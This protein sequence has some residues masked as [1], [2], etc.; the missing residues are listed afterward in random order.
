MAQITTVIPT[1]RRPRLL[2]RAIRSV[3]AQ[4]YPDFEIH[5]WDNASG[6]ETADVVAE[7]A[8]R[9]PRA[10]YHCHPENIGPVRNF[11]YGA[12]QVATPFFNFLSDDDIL[13]PNFFA[14]GMRLLGESPDAGAFAG[15][16]IRSDPAGRT[17]RSPSLAWKPGVYAPPRG[18]FGILGH[19]NF[20]W[21]SMLFRRAAFDAIGGLDEAVGEPS[22]LDLQLRMAARFPLVVSTDPCA[23]FVI[24][25]QNASQRVSPVR[26][27][28]A[29]ERIVG[30]FE[31]DAALAA[32]DREQIVRLMKRRLRAEII[33]KSFRAAARGEA[34]ASSIF[35]PLGDDGGFFGRR[36]NGTIGL[37]NRRDAIGAAARWAFRAADGARFAVKHGAARIRLRRIAAR[38]R[39]GLHPASPA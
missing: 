29:F 33:A 7:I 25:T 26:L 2:S 1:Y 14:L 19:G 39:S 30:K 9:D 36:F 16:S 23:V 13:L 28:R 17:Y 11:A 6:D 12:A 15:A 8:R 34:I 5:V 18:C 3:L 35:D 37:L 27:A 10:H 31:A 32:A 21:T 22:D 20:D 24:G 4:T 38:V